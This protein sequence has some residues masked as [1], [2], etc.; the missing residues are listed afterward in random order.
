MEVKMRQE[1]TIKII[2]WVAENPQ[3]MGKLLNA[4]ESTTPEECIE[5]IDLLYKQSLEYLIPILVYTTQLDYVMGIVWSRVTAEGIGR[6][7]ESMGTEQMLTD[8]KNK[9]REEI[10][11]KEARKQ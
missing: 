6:V 1:E 8:I 9:I 2:K 5:V 10:K 3:V 4:E 7:W 11:L